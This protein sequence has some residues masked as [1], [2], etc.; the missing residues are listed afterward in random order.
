MQIIRGI[1]SAPARR[2][3]LT[4]GNFDGV[5]LGHRALLAHLAEAA[6][7]RKLATAVLTFE[8]HPREFFS[9]GSAPA[10][11]TDLREKA[12]LLSE[13][14]VD[15]LY[16]QRFDAAFS[17]L[18]AH[19]FVRALD[20][21]GA[22][23]VIVGDDF[24]FGRERTGD[25]GFLEKAAKRFELS[26]MDSVMVDG[27]RVSSSAIRVALAEG[28]FA[29]AK[30]LLGRD[31]SI[32]GKVIHGD[33]LGAKLGFPTANVQLKN[34]RP[35]IAGIF[36]AEIAI[37]DGKRRQGVASLGFRPTVSDSSALVLEAHI[38]D[39][40][41]VLY[42]EHATVFFLHKLRDEAKYG[43]LKA[44]SKQIAIDVENAKTWFQ[45][46]GIGIGD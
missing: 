43:D 45:N 19:D 4:I 15:L 6:E 36:V 9:P 31:Y 3:A 35:P 41:D 39:S 11:L 7:E 5:H 16:V 29:R 25:F 2:I 24:R 8:P 28:R 33:K 37:A 17:R 20:R 21:M 27:E 38:F 42:G 10:R 23:F 26:R 22:R 13:N 32:S 44:L 46:E 30:L 40:E 34:E 18:S 14:D 1:S 12:R